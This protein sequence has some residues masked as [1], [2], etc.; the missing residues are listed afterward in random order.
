MRMI[1][2]NKV[3][4]SYGRNF[5]HTRSTSQAITATVDELE[6]KYGEPRGS[7]RDQVHEIAEQVEIE[8]GD[9]FQLARQSAFR[10][11]L[12]EDVLEHVKTAWRELADQVAETLARESSQASTLDWSPPTD[13][14]VEQFIHEWPERP[15]LTIFFD[16]DGHITAWGIS[17]RV[18][19]YEGVFVQE[20]I[21]PGFSYDTLKVMLSA[22]MYRI[23]RAPGRQK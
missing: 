13:A 21:R 3:I 12:E 4:E 14:Q 11:L 15:A 17:E 2:V 8:L 23:F 19:A 20:P 5:G 22:A 16:Q 10:A 6:E 1:P 18:P 7:I 9:P